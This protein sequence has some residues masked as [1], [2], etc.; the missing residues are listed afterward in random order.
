VFGLFLF[1][2]LLPASAYAAEPFRYPKKKHGGGELKYVNGLP[3]LVVQ[4]TPQ[5]IGEQIGMLGVKPAARLLH[6]PKDFLA[7]IPLAEVAWSVLVSEGKRML[8][9]FPP[10]HLQEMDAIAKA[11]GFDRD[12]IVAANTMFDLKK[13]IACSALIVQPDRSA[14]RGP[15]FGRNL[16]YPSFGYLHEYSLVTIYRPKG[17]HAFASIGFPG[18]VGCLSG[19]NDAGLSL[20]VLE[21]FAV[22]DGQEKYDDTGTPYAL[23]YRRILEECATVDEAERLLKSMKRIT[24]TNLAICDKHGGAVLEVTPKHVARRLPENNVCACTNHFLTPDLKPDELEN[25]FN[26]LKRYQAL[27]K[28]CQGKQHL[29]L[30]DVQ[31][32]LHAAHQGRGTL[33]TMIFEP[34]A[35]RLHL[36]FGTCPSSALPVK[37]L[38]LAPLFRQGHGK[39]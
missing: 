20:A 25:F 14:T 27:L 36:A 8:K 3:V 13:L 2:A 18:V 32:S 30:A 21:V 6:Y 39:D 11:S 10:D 1:A 33:Q 26:T 29:D 4:G 23:C 19:M 24:T 28:T 16:D 37:R 15:L 17:K 31:A 34:A 38:D 22:K 35:L 7:R 5:E 12:Y 9:Q